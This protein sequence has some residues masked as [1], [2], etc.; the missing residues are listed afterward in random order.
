[1]F[2]RL[3]VKQLDGTLSF[4]LLLSLG[5]GRL[6]QLDCEEHKLHLGVHVITIMQNT[7]ESRSDKLS[8]ALCDTKSTTES[9]FVC[10]AAAS[11]ATITRI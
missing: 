9:S 2:V 4:V 11:A 3:N 6:V 8:R 5:L 1:M 10:F 7:L